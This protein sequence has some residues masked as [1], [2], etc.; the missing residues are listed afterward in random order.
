M[1]KLG[2]EKRGDRVCKNSQLR[3]IAQRQ[4]IQDM[5]HIGFDRPFGQVQLSSDFTVCT[6]L[7][8]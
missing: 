1:N 8:N 5:S 7:T 6:A 2:I 3:S 4:T